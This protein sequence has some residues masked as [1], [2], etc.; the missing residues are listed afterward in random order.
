MKIVNIIKKSIR[1]KL[2]SV[3]AFV[4]AVLIIICSWAVYN[5][6][7]LS[8]SIDNIMISNYLSI[9]AAQN[10]LTSIE[11]QDSKELSMLLLDN[12]QNMEE[13]REN[14][15]IFFLNYKNASENITENNEEKIVK[16]I[17][18]NYDQ[19]QALY[20]KFEKEITAGN[21]D[22]AEEIYAYEI[23]PLF[24]KTKTKIKELQTVN[25]EGMLIRKNKAKKAS[26]NAVISTLLISVFSIAITLI[27][28]ILLINK[29]LEPIYELIK[30][31]KKVSKGNYK[32]KIATEGTDEIGQ[33]ETEFNN[34]KK[35]LSEYELMNIDKLKNEK[36]KAESIV[37]TINDGIIV[38]D[39]DKKVILV[40][41]AAEKIFDISE[42]D[43]LNLSVSEVTNNQRLSDFISN[44]NSGNFRNYIDIS[45]EDK[46]RRINY[47]RVL[48]SSIL[49]HDEAIGTVILLQNITKF[50]ELDQMK[51][52]FLATASHELKTPLTSIIMSIDILTKELKNK[53]GSDEYELLEIIEED[54]GRLKKLI[55]DLLD[56]EKIE[57]GKDPLVISRFSIAALINKVI[58]K[59][60]IQIK[61]LNIKV[62]TDF[63]NSTEENVSGDIE[64]ID[65]VLT[66]LISNSLKFIPLDR[67]GK[68]KIS[69]AELGERMVISVSDNGVGISEDKLPHIFEKFQK[70]RESDDKIQKGTGL[71]LA[72]CKQ[73]IN[74]HGGDI[75]VESKEGAGTT[76]YFTLKNE[77]K[78]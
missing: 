5:F 17:K 67:A 24:E 42:K 26:D 58:E 41:R 55:N 9:E 44:F 48:L 27:L 28:V 31:I 66:N 38:L 21:K 64:K 6:N 49:R 12:K 57:S 45:I 29:I 62:I 68:L 20:E 11:R 50:K 72:I 35:K 77:K 71:G 19:Y 53:V 39:N 40:N 54:S 63:E 51:S 60:R 73:I 43:I 37:E 32:I 1:Y 76:F 78:S 61:E 16:E 75:W 10:M 14:S 7:M 34:M 70:I 33:L 65:R 13:F 47:Y 4:T 22:T 18:Y 52:D 59:F 25:Q 69:I 2:L 23:L 15:S 46:K 56:L 8:K 74:A 36:Q 3:F 30:Q